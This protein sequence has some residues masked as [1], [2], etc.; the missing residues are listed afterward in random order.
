MRV[1]SKP[2]VM[3]HT[4]GT[5][6]GKNEID[7]WENLVRPFLVHILVHIFSAGVG[8]AYRPYTIRGGGGG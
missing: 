7:R 1:I 3:A 6:V 4:K 2:D 5:I 8:V